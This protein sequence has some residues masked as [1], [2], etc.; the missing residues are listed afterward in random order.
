MPKKMKKTLD[1]PTEECR[2]NTVVIDIDTEKK[3]IT[4]LSVVLCVFLVLVLIGGAVS[5][6]VKTLG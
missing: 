1:F 6:S 4:I 3:M 2:I 5:G